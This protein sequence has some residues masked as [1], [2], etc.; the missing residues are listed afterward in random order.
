MTPAALQP[1]ASLLIL[2]LLFDPSLVLC[3][4]AALPPVVHSPSV[5]A[6]RVVIISAAA[7]CL[8]MEKRLVPFSLRAR[9]QPLA[10]AE[11]GMQR[12]ECSSS[13]N[14]QELVFCKY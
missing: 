9:E 3:V 6:R 7:L 8:F 13:V 10:D 14:Y 4:H 1:R 5:L 12:V 11:Q 2:L